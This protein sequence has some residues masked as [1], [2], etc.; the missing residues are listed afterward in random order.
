LKSE[1]RRFVFFDIV[2]DNSLTDDVNTVVI[3][4]WLNSADSGLESGL[5]TDDWIGKVAI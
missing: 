5:V 4:A 2:G 3:A 1:K